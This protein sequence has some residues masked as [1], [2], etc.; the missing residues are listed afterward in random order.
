MSE[1]P[2]DSI[3][4]FKKQLDKCLLRPMR[5]AFQLSFIS[6]D[7]KSKPVEMYMVSIPDLDKKVCMIT[8]PRIG[9]RLE[10]L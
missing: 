7:G 6:E 4:C 10:K 1:C 8:I 3:E 5:T 2:A 9:Y